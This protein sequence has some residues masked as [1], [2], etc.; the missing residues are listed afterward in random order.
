MVMDKCGLYGGRTVNEVRRIGMK[1]LLM[2]STLALAVLAVGN[3]AQA[4]PTTTCTGTKIVEVRWTEEVVTI[5]EVREQV[6]GAMDVVDATDAQPGTYFV[7]S[8]VADNSIWNADGG[9]YYR[10]DSQDWG[11]THTYVN[12][13]D[14][15]PATIEAVTAATL[16]IRAYDV[17]G[18]EVDLIAGDGTVLGPLAVGDGK[19]STTTFDLTGAVLDDL[20]DGSLDVWM[21]I[22]AANQGIWRVALGSSK[23]TVDYGTLELVETVETIT[24]VEYVEVPCPHPQVIPAPGAII[25]SSLGVGLVG[26]L[27]RRRTL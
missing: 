27:R 2:I 12:P 24:H 9:K 20:L 14:L 19:W 6:T 25:L 7:P 3:Q 11:W 5:E 26:F 13:A 22:D 18:P 21:D 8:G 1:K 10:R 4:G 23:L 15:L 16:E 17:D